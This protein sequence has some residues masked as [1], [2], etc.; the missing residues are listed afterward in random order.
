MDLEGN[1]RPRAETIERMFQVAGAVTFLASV[2]LLATRILT[3]LYERL[4][5]KRMSEATASRRSR[6]AE[7]EFERYKR[8][9]ESGLLSHEEFEEKKLQLKARLLGPG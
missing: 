9:L 3:T 6:H 7:A 2:I 5:K 1:A 4:L 8:L